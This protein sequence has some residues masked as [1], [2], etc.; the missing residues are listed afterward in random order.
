[1]NEW[2]GFIQSLEAVGWRQLVWL[3]GSRR[4]C[5]DQV[6]QV[7]QQAGWQ[8]IHCLVSDRALAADFDWPDAFGLQPASLALRQ[9]GDEQNHLVV[10]AFAGL[11]PDALAAQVG[12]VTAGGLVLLLTPL[13]WGKAPDCDQA[14]LADWPLH[15]SDL[16]ARYLSRLARR[17]SAANACIEWIEGQCPDLALPE[18]L[19]AR[20]VWQPSVHEQTRLVNTLLHHWHTKPRTPQLVSALR[21]RGKSA[22]LGLAAA[23]WLMQHPDAAV[24]VVAATAANKKVLLQHLQQALEQCG[25]QET[26]AQVSC[27]PPDALPVLQAEDDR[28]RLLIVDEAASLPVPQLVHYLSYPVSCVFVTTLQGYEGSGRGF[29]LRFLPQLKRDHPDLA[30][31]TLTQP[32][33][34]AEDDPLEAQ[35]TDLLRLDADAGMD[36]AGSRPRSQLGSQPG[37]KVQL[38]ST[39]FSI[40]W[41]DRDDLAANEALLQQVFGLLMLAHYQTRPAD[42]RQLLDAPYGQL[43]L[44]RFNQQPVA[45]AQI[46]LEGGLPSDLAEAVYLGQRRVQG[47]LLAQSMAFHGGWAE[48]AT[49]RWWRIQRILVHPAWQHQGIGQRLL[50]WLIDEAHQAAEPLDLLGSSFAATPALLPFWARQGFRPLRVGLTRDHVSGEPALQVGLGISVRGQAALGPWHERFVETWQPALHPLYAAAD[51]SAFELGSPQASGELNAADQQELYAFAWGH[52][53]LEAT[54]LALSRWFA[55]HASTAEVDESAWNLLLHQ[56]AG[57]TQAAPLLGFGGKKSLL[58]ALRAQ[59]AATGVGRR[60]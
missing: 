55:R 14:R 53:S 9:L 50:H 15:W 46:Q 44:V 59:V 39:D 28:H 47:H 5:L 33:R 40:D 24:W 52:R 7:A 2:S 22:A 8:P 12:R 36:Q 20:P 58:T 1:M 17:L 35:V 16:S 37:S 49:L 10:D 54:R 30:E 34:W 29:A 51:L 23:N 42:L 11:C 3:R 38:S 19:N 18:C 57:L 43:A 48:A 56:G 41:L 6:Q 4:W 25:K 31:W 13:D 32:L 45:L 26:M 60:G 21:G 27:P